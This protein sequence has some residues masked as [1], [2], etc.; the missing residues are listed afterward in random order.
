MEMNRKWMAFGCALS[1]ILALTACGTGA[2]TEANRLS[3]RQDAPA[4]HN[5]LEDGRYYAGAD[6]VVVQRRDAGE[7]EWEKLGRQ[8]RESWDDMREDAEKAARGAADDVEHER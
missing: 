1:L 7:S 2:E 8:L 5:L 3:A 4:H 6:G